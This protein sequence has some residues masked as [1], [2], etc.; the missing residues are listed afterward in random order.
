MEFDSKTLK[1]L[2][3]EILEKKPEIYKKLEKDTQNLSDESKLYYILGFSAGV[4]L[5]PDSRFSAEEIK[6]AVRGIPTKATDKIL[7]Y[8]YAHSECYHGELA[9]ATGLSD[10]GL[11]TIIKKIEQ[12]PISLIEISREGKYKV[13]NLT[14]EGREYVKSKRIIKDLSGN[15]EPKL[16][17]EEKS[18]KEIVQT[19]DSIDKIE[20]EYNKIK[21]EKR[22]KRK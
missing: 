14:Q 8:L 21:I 22:G 20:K 18:Q 12:C 4:G 6:K 7:D 3:L 9:K 16:Q 1:R 19:I 13:Y 10:S 17:L 2:T 5:L 11:S 15:I